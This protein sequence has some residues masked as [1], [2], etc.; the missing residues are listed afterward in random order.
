VLDPPSHEL[1]VLVHASLVGRAQIDGL[2][3]RCLGLLCDGAEAGL[4]DRRCRQ[5]CLSLNLRE[6]PGLCLCLAQVFVPGGPGRKEGLHHCG[7]AALALGVLGCGLEI[8]D[9]DARAVER[10]YRFARQAEPLA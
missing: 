4:D 2:P 10:G 7:V 5:T 1:G 3:E 9:L 8:L 6:P